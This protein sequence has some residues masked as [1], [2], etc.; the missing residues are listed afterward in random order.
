MQNI[1]NDSRAIRPEFNKRGE[2]RRGFTLLKT[3]DSDL[4]SDISLYKLPRATLERV[5]VSVSNEAVMK[6]ILKFF[7]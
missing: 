6:W 5:C 2:P 1:R 7:L 3:I 4:H